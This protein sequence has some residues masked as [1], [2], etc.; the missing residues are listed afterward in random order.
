MSAA[1]VFAY[2]QNFVKI[3]KLLVMFIANTNIKYFHSPC[4]VI[5]WKSIHSW[6][7]QVIW[8]K[9]KFKIKIIYFNSIQNTHKY[10][11]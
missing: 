10:I 8:K 2:I 4:M 3:K 5:F 7:K 6:E 1:A 9:Y 11:Q